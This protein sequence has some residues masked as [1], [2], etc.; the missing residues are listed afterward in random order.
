MARLMKIGMLVYSFYETDSRVMRYAET[1][2]RYGHKVDV[3]AL[4]QEGYPAYEN[5]KG[6]DIYRIQERIVDEQ[7]PFSYGKK[8]L[9][10]LCRAAWFLAKHSMQG[11]YD[12][13]HVHNMP[14]F[15]VFAALAPKL[16]GAKVILDIH[17]LLPELYANKFQG[18]K[19]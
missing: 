18:G 5:M 9:K 4:L 13:V 15:L 16:H 12:L 11:A 2:A 19:A 8:L 6:V 14:N 7:G 1:L 17:D 3:M 10:F